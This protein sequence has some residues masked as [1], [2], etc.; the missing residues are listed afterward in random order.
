[1]IVALVYDLR[2][3]YLALGYSA[4]AV[5][6]FDSDETVE[7][8]AAALQ[9]HG[10]RVERV[11][12]GRALARALADGARFDLVFSIAEGVQGRSREAQVP[13]LCELYD[14]PYVFSDPL[15]MAATLDKGVAKRIVRDAGVATAPFAVVEADMQLPPLGFAYPVFA[16]PLAEGTGKGCE[17]QSICRDRDELSATVRSLGSRYRQ[18]V[19]VESYL[20]G[21]E[22]TVGIVGCGGD[23]RVI[24]TME[25]VLNAGADEG[26]YSYRNKEQCESLVTYRRGDDA[27]AA[28]AAECA[29]AAYRALN[30]RDAGRVD[31][32]CD[33]AGKPYFLEVNPIAGL[34]PEHSDLPIIATLHGHDFN[35]LI[36]EILAS[37]EQRLGLV[38][39]ARVIA[40]P[41]STASR[42]FVPVIHAAMA[43]RADEADTEEAAHA[44]CAALRRVGF[45]SAVERFVAAE[46]APESFAARPPHAIFNLVEA[47]DGRSSAAVMAAACLERW[48]LRFTGNDFQA[49]MTTASK[50]AVKGV[51][52][53]FGIRV[54][55]LVAVNDDDRCRVIVKPVW[56]HASLGIGPRS[57]AMSGEA[58]AAILH[59]RREF[60][61]EFFAE[62]F[63][64]GREFNVSLLGPRQQPEV[65]PIQETLFVDWEPGRPRVVDYE[66]KWETDSAAYRGTPRRFG[67]EATEPDLARRLRDQ[68]LA[69]WSRLGLGGYARI[70]FRVDD[71]RDIYAIDVNAN[72]GIGDD[73]GFVA[74]ALESGRD[75]DGLIRDLVAAA[76]TSPLRVAA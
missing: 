53:A 23:S 24:G 14:L 76:T 52:G 16:K 54:P 25:V 20:E 11:G 44:V 33:A 71:R 32:R 27:T 35:W 3:D 12:S 63:I 22:F 38:R 58:E 40:V 65:L 28:A 43:G 51:L 6:E 61:S 57:V 39:P 68:A 13:A 18:A 1:M 42:A 5:A 55:R 66:A 41:R 64:E 4:E 37:A 15:T 17:V 56:E 21:R 46:L 47:I 45:D 60:G 9:S 72:P 74:A 70:D 29:L 69:I 73:A 49:L 59:Q 75:F 67:I 8:L 30:C 26:V 2:S 36:G 31:I 34:H 19:I 10:Y 48:G 50:L 62:E 7:G